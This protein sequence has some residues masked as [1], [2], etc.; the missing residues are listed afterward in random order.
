MSYALKLSPMA[1][2]DLS[3]IKNYIMKD[4]ESI[5]LGQ[6][7]EILH[8]IKNLEQFPSLGRPLQNKVKTKTDMRYLDIKDLYYAFYR[9]NGQDVEI[10]R[11]LSTRQDYI[12]ALDL[13]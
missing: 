13:K 1:I 4:G 9:V 5:A 10:V 7:Q 3:S 8:N 11:I 12:Q 2:D 6:V